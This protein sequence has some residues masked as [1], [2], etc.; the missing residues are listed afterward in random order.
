MTLAAMI[1][2][3]NPIRLEKILGDTVLEWQLQSLSFT[4]HGRMPIERI[5]IIAGANLEQISSKVAHLKP[6]VECF[7]DTKQAALDLS[8]TDPIVFLKRVQ[9]FVSAESMLS[10][11]ATEPAIIHGGG[12]YG[13]MVANLG[14][15]MQ[16]RSSDPDDLFDCCEWNTLFGCQCSHPEDLFQV[17]TRQDISKAQSIA[18]KRI[19]G[20]WLDSGVVFLDTEST[21]IG[22]RVDISCSGVTIEPQV[23]L[24]G[25]VAIGDGA[26]IGQGSIIADSRIGNN[27]EIRPYCVIHGSEIGD[28]ARVGPFAHLREG[29]LLEE[30]VH[31]GN[32]VETKKAHMHL[33]SKANHLSYLGDCEIG[34]KTNIGA[35]C[36]TCNYDG[37][38]KHR[39]QI[40]SKVFVGSDCQ[41]VAPVTIGDGAILGAGTTLTVNVPDNALALTRAET[42]VLEGGAKKLRARQKKAEA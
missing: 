24:E 14:Q 30:N 18:R 39:T 40:G 33:G 13:P 41:L 25:A 38:S 28:G 11:L 6:R 37:F 31:V 23:R 12:L 8:H 3:R 32:F 19:L 27:A 35:G 15:I 4:R 17:R 16:G 20:R 36:I 2:A 34:E 42:K 1:D 10:L 7:T 9:P 21:F 29:T 5:M 22:P 26:R